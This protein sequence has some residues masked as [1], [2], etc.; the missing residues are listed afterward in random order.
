MRLFSQNFPKLKSHE[1]SEEFVFETYVFLI[2]EICNMLKKS[3]QNKRRG[4]ITPPL[5]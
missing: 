5:L 3:E 1:V 4:G 2:R